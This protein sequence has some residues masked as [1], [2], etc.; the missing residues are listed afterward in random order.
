MALFNSPMNGKITAG[1]YSGKTIVKSGNDILVMLSAL[2]SIKDG[3]NCIILN[4]KNVSS[5]NLIDQSA[6]GKY[7]V[8][9]NWTKGGKSLLEC[10]NKVYTELVKAL[11]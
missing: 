7:T 2:W 11:F 10:D 3:E 6:H 8:Q 4:S 9:I 1:E 5:Y